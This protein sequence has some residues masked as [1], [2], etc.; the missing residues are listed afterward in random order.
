VKLKEIL[1][2]LYKV[3]SQK[4]KVK[5]LIQNAFD[6]IHK[7]E[8]EAMLLIQDLQKEVKKK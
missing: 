5:R 8:I 4:T 3:Q 7:L 1:T 2:R 6:E